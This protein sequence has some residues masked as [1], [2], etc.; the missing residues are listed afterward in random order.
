MP[1]EKVPVIT[2]QFVVLAASEWHRPSNAGARARVLTTRACCPMTSCA[3]LPD[4][5]YPV[6][7]AGLGTSSLCSRTR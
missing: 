2:A 1:G 3:Y 6:R 4:Y 7:R 5:T